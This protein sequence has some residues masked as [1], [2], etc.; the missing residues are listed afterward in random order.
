MMEDWQSEWEDP[1]NKKERKFCSLKDFSS[2]LNRWNFTS[3]IECPCGT[4]PHY[5]IECN[6][7]MSLHMRKPAHSLSKSGSATLPPIKSQ[8]SNASIYPPPQRLPR[9]VRY[10]FLIKHLTKQSSK[11]LRLPSIGLHLSR[12][13]VSLLSH[14]CPKV[15][16]ILPFNTQST[17]SFHKD[18]G[19]LFNNKVL[20]H[21]ELLLYQC[22]HLKPL[23]SERITSQQ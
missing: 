11:R 5:A 23:L 2:Y 8:D 14:S 6:L 18:P 10:H 22:C 16:K 17:E 20:I 1:A 3:F 9:A 12:H 13:K 7:N 4:P 21:M 19:L 15:L